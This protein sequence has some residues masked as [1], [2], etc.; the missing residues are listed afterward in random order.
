MQFDFLALLVVYCFLN[1]L[2]S[3]FCLC[4]EAKG[5]YLYLHL[6]WNLIFVLIIVIF[7]KWLILWFILVDCN[8]L[9][10]GFVLCVFYTSSQISRPRSMQWSQASLSPETSL[11]ELAWKAVCIPVELF[12][13]S[14]AISVRVEGWW[15][16]QHPRQCQHV[17]M[18]LGSPGNESCQ[19]PHSSHGPWYSLRSLLFSSAALFSLRATFSKPLVWPSALYPNQVKYIYWG[20][21][22]KFGML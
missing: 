5:F 12:T 1:L 14:P 6:G 20:R 16:S 4:E 17:V 18:E 2:L 21:E 7:L 9:H 11:Q 22:G 13:I 10:S 19:R 3:S 8:P 15:M